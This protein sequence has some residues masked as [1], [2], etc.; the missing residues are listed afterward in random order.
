VSGA[1]EASGLKQRGE[2]AMGREEPGEEG[3]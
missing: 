2:K 3:D 1:L